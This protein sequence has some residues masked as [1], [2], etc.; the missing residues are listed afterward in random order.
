MVGKR[1]VKNPIAEVRGFAVVALEMIDVR[2]LTND[3]VFGV[4]GFYREV[5]RKTG[6]CSWAESASKNYRASEGGYS[7]R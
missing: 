2:A 4:Q 5:R 3:L 6:A 7:W 1:A